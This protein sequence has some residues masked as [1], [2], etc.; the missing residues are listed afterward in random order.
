MAPSPARSV[1]CMVAG[2]NRRLTAE[3]HL[4]GLADLAGK[5]WALP[6]TVIGS[7]YG[8]LGYGVGTLFGTNPDITFGNN[9]IQFINSPLMGSAMTFGNS[10]IY[11][12][13]QQFQPDS[14]RFFDHTL[15]V[16]EMQHTFQAQVLGPLY[17]P[18]HAL[19]GTGALI[20]NRGDWHGPANVLETG[21]HSASPQP[22]P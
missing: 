18:A 2:C 7:V 5:I 16:E 4:R 17:L 10:I 21:A 20:F 12:T 13:G 14:P 1:I 11:G 19:L 8:G 6:N 22:W 15:G 9:A 3:T